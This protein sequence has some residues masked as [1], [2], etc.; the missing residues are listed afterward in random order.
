[1]K[2]YGNADYRELITRLL[3]KRGANP[4]NEIKRWTADGS[5]LY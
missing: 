2:P 4:N 5:V 3:L 1:M